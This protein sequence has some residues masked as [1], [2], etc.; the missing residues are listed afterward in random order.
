MRTFSTLIYLFTSN[1]VLNAQNFTKITD[2]ALVNYQSIDTLDATTLNALALYEQYFPV[3]S[4]HSYAKAWL[5]RVL[6]NDYPLYMPVMLAPKLYET[7]EQGNTNVE[8]YAFSIYP[9]PSTDKVYLAGSF[10]QEDNV[11]FEIYD[12]TGKLIM[13][14]SLTGI[15]APLAIAFNDLSSGTYTVRLMVN[16]NEVFS[17]QL[18]VMK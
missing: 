9:N 1:F 15:T 14:K 6:G 13:I 18:V 16:E 12:I 17:K 3:T 7:D 2:D 8:P 10:A 4:A 11:Q 5:R